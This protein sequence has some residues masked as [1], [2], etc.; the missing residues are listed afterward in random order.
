[1]RARAGTKVET[2]RMERVADFRMLYYRLLCYQSYAILVYSRW[3]NR[4][5]KRGPS[6]SPSSASTST[7]ASLLIPPSRPRSTI[8]FATEPVSS[9]LRQALTSDGLDEVEVQKG[10]SQIAKG[11]VFLHEDVKLVHRNLNL[12]SVVVN[13]KVSWMFWKGPPRGWRAGERRGA[14]HSLVRLRFEWNADYP[15]P[16]LNREIGNYQ[17]LV[18]RRICTERM[19]FPLAGNS[20]NLTIPSRRAVN[21]TTITSVRLLPPPSSLLPF[22]QF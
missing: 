9:S 20:P 19:E 22:S 10:V 11:L 2:K 5:K 3:P 21:E 4:L 17:D 6:A 1:M 14:E 12:E 7:S 8:S 13:D 18:S 16:C 15:F